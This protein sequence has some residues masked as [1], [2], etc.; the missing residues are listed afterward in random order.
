MFGL[1]KIPIGSKMRV[2]FLKEK[3][4]YKDMYTTD[5]KLEIKNNLKNINMSLIKTKAS[6]L[7]KISRDKLTKNECLILSGIQYF[8][9]KSISLPSDN[10]KIPDEIL[11]LYKID[12]SEII[13]KLFY[14]Q[15][16]TYLSMIGKNIKNVKYGLDEMDDII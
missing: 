9:I 15:V 11:N 10:K 2:I 12:E 16:E 14:G 6:E 7:Y 5:E 13:E 4:Y 1:N 8:D 3:T